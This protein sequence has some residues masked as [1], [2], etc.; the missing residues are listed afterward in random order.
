[1]GYREPSSFFALVR[2]EKMHV[3]RLGAGRAKIKQ[4]GAIIDQ[5][6]DVNKKDPDFIWTCMC[7]Y[8]Q[9]EWAFG[10]ADQAVFSEADALAEEIISPHRTPNP[11]AFLRPALSHEACTCPFMGK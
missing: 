8:R 3:F 6:R 11:L 4:M 9:T 10:Y 2:H 1:M 7:S 5:L